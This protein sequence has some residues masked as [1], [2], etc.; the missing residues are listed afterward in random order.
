MKYKDFEGDI[1][2]LV[3][4]KLDEI[5]EK[6]HVKILHAVESGSRAWGFA[7]PDSDYDVRFIY[8]RRKE[9]YLRLETIKDTLDWELDETLDINGWDIKKV[10]Q[11]FHKSNATLYEWAN[12]PVVYRTTDE[13]K[14]VYEVGKQ[15]FSCKSSMYHYYGTAN[16]TYN[17]YLNAEYVK[18]KKYF[19]ALRPIL[20]AKWIEQKKCP[21]PVLFQD[22]VDTVLEEE[23]K[24]PVAKLVARKIKMAESDKDKRL[25][26][27]SEYLLKNIFYYKDMLEDTSDDRYPDWEPLNKVFL[28]L[29]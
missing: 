9:D 27:I 24:E 14:K 22:L 10:L 7:S 1:K 17:E 11:H 18:Y 26:K 6:E 4:M 12:S 20:A 28:E 19:Y 2:D 15:Y 21:P 29:L 25:V 5:E 3:N 8:V 23:M 13:W 16:K